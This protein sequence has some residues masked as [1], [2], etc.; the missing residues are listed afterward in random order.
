[1]V[2]LKDGNIE[3]KG[4]YKE[5]QFQYGTIKRYIAGAVYIGW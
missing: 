5:F 1:M 3:L 2:R 4:N